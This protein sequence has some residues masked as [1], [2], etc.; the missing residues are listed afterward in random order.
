[1]LQ[2]LHFTLRLIDESFALHDGVLTEEPPDYRALNRFGQLTLTTNRRCPEGIAALRKCLTLPVP[3]GE[4]SHAEIHS[5]LS[6]LYELAGDRVAAQS[7]L[8]AASALDTA[9]LCTTAALSLSQ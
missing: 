6:Q 1:M 7:A 2:N 3:A 8:Q 4:P 9:P 5:I